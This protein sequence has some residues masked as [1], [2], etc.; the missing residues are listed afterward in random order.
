MLL[1]LTIRPVQ[2]QDATLL[3]A[4]ALRSKAYWG[5]SEEFMAAC[6]D[7]LNYTS[8]QFEGPQY[9]G[10]V[11][12]ASGVPIAFYLLEKTSDSIAELDA[13][14]VEPEYIGKGVGRLLIEHA[15]KQAKQLGYITIV[16]QGDPHAEH[17]YTSVGALHSGTRE[18]GSIPGRQLPLFIIRIQN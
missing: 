15:K 9:C 13:L 7:E 12:L 4:L 3:S 5:Y 1:N 2:C 11:C 8:K 6:K 16:I 14:F 10:H 17:F 18:S